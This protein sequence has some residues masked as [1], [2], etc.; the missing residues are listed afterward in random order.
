MN[1]ILFDKFNKTE[2]DFNKIRIATKNKLYQRFIPEKYANTGEDPA[3][4]FIEFTKKDIIRPL[5]KPNNYEK[6]KN[7][8]QTG[9]ALNTTK[10]CTSP[11]MVNKFQKFKEYNFIKKDKINIEKYRNNYF[12]T[13]YISVKNPIEKYDKNKMTFI[14]AKSIYVIK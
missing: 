13:D 5:E 9:W 4:K 11:R 2:T 7:S 10:L 3:G 1:P 8:T 6:I 14:E 12:K